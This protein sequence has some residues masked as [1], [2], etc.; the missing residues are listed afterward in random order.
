MTKW[1][2]KTTAGRGTRRTQLMANVLKRSPDTRR[3]QAER[4]RA[5]KWR[6]QRAARAFFEQL[7]GITVFAIMGVDS[8]KIDFKNQWC[9]IDLI[10][11]QDPIEEK[12]RIQE[13]E[14]ISYIYCTT[15]CTH[16]TILK[17]PVEFDLI[18]LC[19]IRAEKQLH[20][21][22]ADN[23]QGIQSNEDIGS[24]ELRTDVLPA[25]RQLFTDDH[26]DHADWTYGRRAFSMKDDGDKVSCVINWNHPLPNA[27]AADFA[28][29]KGRVV[30]TT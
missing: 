18:I 2:I 22:H 13:K 3:K 17:Q 27:G 9:V 15:L 21:L 7:I 8:L 4:A 20:Y 19:Q 6:L 25:M 26:D 28:L 5:M 14:E 10:K 24:Y 16:T 29:G 1:H 11:Y 12:E 30:P 23:Y